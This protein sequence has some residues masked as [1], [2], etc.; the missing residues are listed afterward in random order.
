MNARLFPAL[1]L[2]AAGALVAP[3]GHA[4]AMLKCTMRFD[5]ASW[6][7]LYKHSSGTGTVSCS[8]GSHLKVKLTANGGGLAVGK[9]NIKGGKANFSDVRSID[10]TLGTYAAATASM[11]LPKNGEA[12]VM[13]KGEVNMSLA[14]AGKGFGL[15]VTVGGM[16]LEKV[17]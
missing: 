10:E 7:I 3:A 2:L 14:G 5:L 6:S 8:D 11:G 17:P 13:T 16:T 4:A 1:L 12:Q 15:G 9:S